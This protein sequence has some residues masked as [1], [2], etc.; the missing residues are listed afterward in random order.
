MNK[1]RLKQ[2]ARAA[3]KG[4]WERDGNQVCPVADQSKSLA[5]FVNV[6]DAAFVVAAQPA[7]VLNL[8]LEIEHLTSSLARVT[9]DR[10]GLLEAGA[11]L[12]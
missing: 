10:D 5:T 2:L 6:P 11:H 7:V 12:L 9:E 8:I 1:E 3:T 4:E